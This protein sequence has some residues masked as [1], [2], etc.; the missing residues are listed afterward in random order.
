MSIQEYRYFHSCG[1]LQHPSEIRVFCIY[2]KREGQTPQ[3]YNL[4]SYF[5]G[6]ASLKLKKINQ[7][8][9]KIKE[10]ILCGD[11]RK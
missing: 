9:V 8:P 7:R 4:I 11:G 2:T 5:I 10:F 6:Y 3:G 1:L